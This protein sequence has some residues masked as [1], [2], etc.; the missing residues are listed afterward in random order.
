MFRSSKRSAKSRVR[1]T[2]CEKF[3]TIIPLFLIWCLRAAVFDVHYTQWYNEHEKIHRINM[4]VIFFIH[5]EQIRAAGL[6]FF[7][8]FTHVGLFCTCAEQASPYRD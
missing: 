7:Q 3:G 2:L 8:V 5:M 4:C 6:F 1:Y